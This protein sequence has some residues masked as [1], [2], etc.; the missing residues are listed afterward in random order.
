MEASGESQKSV[1]TEGDL[2]RGFSSQKNHSELSSFLLPLEHYEACVVSF[3]HWHSNTVTHGVKQLEMI[4]ILNIFWP[5]SENK[6]IFH[7]YCE[8]QKMGTVTNWG[9]EIAIMFKSSAI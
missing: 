2:Q 1:V 9:H 4:N 8:F 6:K 7:L 3:V 5:L